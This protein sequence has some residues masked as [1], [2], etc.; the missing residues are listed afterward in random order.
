MAAL[1]RAEPVDGGFRVNGRWPFASGCDHC[2]YIV[3]GSL[4]FDGDQMRVLEGGFPDWRTIVFR[5]DE[6]EIL[7]TWRVQGLRGTGSHDIIVKDLF[8]PEE[9]A[10]ALA[11]GGPVQDGPLYRFPTFGF[12]ALTVA[13]VATGIAR[14]AIDEFRDLAAKKTPLGGRTALKDREIVQNELGRA[15]GELRSARAFMYEVTAEIWDAVLAGDQATLEQRAMLRMAC[16]HAA[17]ASV[18]AVDRVYELAGTTAIFDGN[19]I[20]RCFRDVHTSTQHIMLNAVNYTTAG[21]S[22]L[23]VEPQTLAL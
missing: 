2:A 14:R 15:E 16:A 5:R 23:G 17:A 21:Q 4:V 22:M 7:D 10:I 1:G 19:I 8:M 9:R 18:K 13:P 12:L 20:Q 3:G 11:A 6:L